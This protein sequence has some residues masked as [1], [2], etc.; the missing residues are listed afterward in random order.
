MS[1]PDFGIALN[2]ADSVGHMSAQTNAMS[3]GIGDYLGKTRSLIA[4]GLAFL[5]VAG[6]AG[7]AM[8]YRAKT[9]DAQIAG[10]G[11]SYMTY[12]KPVVTAAV[13]A[14][15]PGVKVLNTRKTLG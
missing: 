15:R 7:Q 13:E 4:G 1:N 6:P 5:A 2:A 12:T 9:A 3:G 8:A 10:I 14:T 11:E